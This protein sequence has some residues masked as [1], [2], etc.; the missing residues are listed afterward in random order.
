MSYFSRSNLKLLRNNILEKVDKSL[1]QDS[2]KTILKQ[3]RISM[4]VVRQITE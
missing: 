3:N 4:F 1:Y 2:L